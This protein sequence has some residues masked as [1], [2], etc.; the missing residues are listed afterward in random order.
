LISALSTSFFTGIANNPDVPA[1]VS[2]QAQV[3][4][5]GGVPFLSDDDLNDALGEADV[6]AKS[7]AAIVD[8]NSAARIDA[9]RTSL[10]LL[11]LIALLAL[12]TAGS[13]PTRPP[14][15]VPDSDPE[16][17]RRQPPVASPA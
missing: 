15:D 12:F 7:S 3:E 5:A 10:S 9:L 1:Q 14:G 8:A 6:D 4:L 17:D 13:L 16:A 2:D 11:G